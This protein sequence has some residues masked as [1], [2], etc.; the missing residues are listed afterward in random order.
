MKPE[1][2]KAIEAILKKGRCAEIRPTKT[3]FVVLETDRH[4]VY[5]EK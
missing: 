5:E 4:K 3:G 1:T 2:I